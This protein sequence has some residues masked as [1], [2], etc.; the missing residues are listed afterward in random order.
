MKTRAVVLASILVLLAGSFLWAQ[1]PQT[2]GEQKIL[3]KLDQISKT[4]QQ[5]LGELELVK[6]ELSVIKVR[7]TR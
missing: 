7:S 1:A 6:Q 2:P 3:E 4:Q 5:I